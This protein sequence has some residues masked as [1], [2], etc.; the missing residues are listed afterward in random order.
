[1]RTFKFFQFVLLSISLSLIVI[2]CKDDDDDTTPTPVVYDN[3][4]QLKVGNYWIYQ[5]FDIDSSGT[6]T[7]TAIYDSCY[8]EKD[9]LIAGFTYYKMIRP[10]PF[11]STQS[12]YYVKDSLHYLVEAGGKILFSSL[13]FTNIFEDYYIT[14]SAPNDTVCRIV[15]KMTEQGFLISTPAG[16]FQTSNCQSQYQM[17]PNWTFAGA[18]RYMNTRFARD[19]GIVTETLPFFAST[20]NHVERRLVHYHLN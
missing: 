15:K 17:Y 19:V 10:S 13:D 11:T 14:A 16:N 5:R 9:T 18:L 4:T 3:Y 1:M 12:I 7:P 20:S 8:I 2:S 6:S